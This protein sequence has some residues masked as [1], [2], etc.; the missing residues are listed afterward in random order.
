ML[1]IKILSIGKTKEPWLEQAIA[2]YQKRLQATASFE[3][4][5]AKQE[6]QL[7]ALVAQSPLPICLDPRGSLFTSEEFSDFLCNKLELGGSR[8]S[9]VIG[10][11]E[12]LPAS[13]KKGSYPQVSLSSLTF[14]HQLTRLVLIEQIYR[15]LE[16]AKG[17][18][19]HKNAGC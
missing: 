1:K 12:G 2:E 4:I 19:Y 7:L 11:A 9:F 8:L 16:I 6:E 13:L 10:G 18:K 3:F 14:T 17:S 15:A 5:W